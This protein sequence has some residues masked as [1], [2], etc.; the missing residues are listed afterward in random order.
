[1]VARPQQLDEEHDNLRAA[2]GWALQTDPDDALLLAVSLWRF[3]LARGHFVEGSWWLERTLAADCAMSGRER[4]RARLA[5]AVLDARQGRSARFTELGA[6]AVADMEQ[7]GSPAEVAFTRVLGGFLETIAGNVRAAAEIASQG[8]AE[9][10]TLGA[11]RVAAAALWLRSLVNLYREDAATAVTCL[12][13]TLAAVDR[14]D[15]DE[16]PFLPVVALSEPLIPCSGMWVP[17][18]EE[19][20]LIGR[21]AGRPQAPGYVWSA[22]GSAYRLKRD[23]T[24]AAAVVRRSAGVF[25]AVGDEA[26][27]AL[28]LNHLGCI[29]R[30]LGQFSDARAHL[31]E[32]LRLRRQLGDRR[33]EN[34]VLANL[35]LV[36]A[37]AGDF[38]AG[39]GLTRVA[40]AQG[41]EVEDGPG[42]A[43]GLLSRA[44]V[45]LFAG[46]LKLSRN[47]VGQA[48]ELFRPQGYRR[49]TGW[50]LQLAAELAQT[51]GDGDAA[52]R[53][54][55]EAAALFT[56][57]DC[58]LGRSR[59][60]A[61]FAGSTRSAVARSAV[62]R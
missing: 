17:V 37:A 53:Y 19:T 54:G 35:G 51:D 9:A 6:T 60:E 47:L 26:G 27:L 15:V 3:W 59:A 34:M 24:S 38:D 39:R 62:A 41:E 30:D 52:R 22:A 58:R 44:V 57:A 40:L 12:H 55:A 2:L 18:F 46:E 61:L 50:A 11:P 32:A 56:D 21:Q 16:P 20:A 48:V 1:V 45:E 42:V 8:L 5:I 23:L 33:G 13:E 29:E 10:E 36:S 7:V 49:M 4:A 28:A 31:S 43:G 25:D 14:V